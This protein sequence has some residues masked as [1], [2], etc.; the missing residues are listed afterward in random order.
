LRHLSPLPEIKRRGGDLRSLVGLLNK[1]R[2]PRRFFDQ[3]VSQFSE[4]LFTYG[5][6]KLSQRLHDFLIRIVSLRLQPF[7]QFG[8]IGDL[9][10]RSSLDNFKAGD[11]D[12]VA[13]GES[14]GVFL[15]LLRPGGQIL[16]L[17]QDLGDLLD[18]KEIRFFEFVP[19]EFHMVLRPSPAGSASPTK[20]AVRTRVKFAL[21]L[22]SFL[23]D[24]FDLLTPL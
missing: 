23:G 20:S 5:L 2:T 4:P 21:A 8:I 12:A 6:L 1:R 14:Q 15:D 7:G 24:R 22:E 18:A 3:T 11:L 17:F 19:G 10:G 16:G 9:P 13:E